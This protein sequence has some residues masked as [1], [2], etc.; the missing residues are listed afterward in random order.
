MILQKEMFENDHHISSET[1]S[2]E[3]YERLRLSKTSFSYDT[4]LL[5]RKTWSIIPI[6]EI[7][8]RN[9]GMGFPTRVFNPLSNSS[10]V[11][12][13][14]VFSACHQDYRITV[15]VKGE[16]YV[17]LRDRSE[18]CSKRSHKVCILLKQYPRLFLEWPCPGL[19]C[20]QRIFQSLSPDDSWLVD[21]PGKRIR[22][23]IGTHKRFHTLEQT[24]SISGPCLET[25]AIPFERT[26]CHKQGKVYPEP[27]GRIA[28]KYFR[29]QFNKDVLFEFCHP[30]FYP[31]IKL[32]V[33]QARQRGYPVNRRLWI[34]DFCHAGS[35]QSRDSE[36]ALEED[37]LSG[38]DA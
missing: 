30:W 11:V 28:A 36:R 33:G 38:P 23:W 7:A 3:Q 15:P 1:M 32:L 13:S 16:R 4:E 10:H 37:D 19:L 24:I 6:S 27:V 20:F 12:E 5:V 26:Q 31:R 2:L 34:I 17:S 21:E 14:N 18:M 25:P 9:I 29:L 22:Q 8:P 35:I